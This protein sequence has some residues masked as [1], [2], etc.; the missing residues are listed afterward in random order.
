[1]TGL[2]MVKFN[3]SPLKVQGSPFDICWAAHS[4]RQPV[5]HLQST[6]FESA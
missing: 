4:L 5:P 2:Q 1:M 6:V 3:G